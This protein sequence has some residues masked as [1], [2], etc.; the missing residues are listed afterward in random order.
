MSITVQPR[1]GFRPSYLALLESGELACRVEDALKKL[2]DCAL[3]NF[4]P[5]ARALRKPALT[6]SWIS[7]RSNSAMAPMIWNIRRPEGVVDTANSIRVFGG[8][9][10]QI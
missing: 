7:D 1:K 3:P 4:L 5:L 9:T 2:A 6:R 8:W 10:L